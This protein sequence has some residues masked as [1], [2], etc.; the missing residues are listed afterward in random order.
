[1]FPD[2]AL[3][4]MPLAEAVAGDGYRAIIP[5]LPGYWP[6]SPVADGDYAVPA[7]AGDLLELMDH[8]GLE[9]AAIVGPDWGACR[10]HHLAA[11]Q[12]DRMTPLVA[13][14][15]PPPAGF[16]ARR[17]IFSEQRTAWYAILLAYAP[18]GAN[19]IRDRRWL[20]AL[21]NSWSPGFH[22]PQWPEVAGL[23]AQ[24]GV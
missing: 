23:L 13:L 9:R 15:P 2:H 17:T 18:D 22:W 4:M 6:S 24:P 21:V 16:A 12:P 8:L 5:A 7:V 3:G 10:G 1:G 19:V 14:A 20:T 11:R